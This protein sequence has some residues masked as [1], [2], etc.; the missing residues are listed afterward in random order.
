[1]FCR[2]C[3]VE[4]PECF[5]FCWNSCASVKSQTEEEDKKK[6]VSFTAFKKRK[7]EKQSTRFQPSKKLKSGSKGKEDTQT[8]INVGYMK[9]EDDKF[10]STGEE[11][12]PLKYQ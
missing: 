3:G 11:R 6:T 8:S 5:N 1:M 4:T 12:F 10:K 7:E 9:F 2:I